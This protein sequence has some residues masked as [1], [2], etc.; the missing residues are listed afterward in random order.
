MH[1]WIKAIRR[2]YPHLKDL[3]DEQILARNC[4]FQGERMTVAQLI[5]ILEGM[6]K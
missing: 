1:K 4:T 6:L 2:Q 3:T 5:P